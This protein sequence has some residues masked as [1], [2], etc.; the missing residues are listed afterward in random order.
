LTV[1]LTNFPGAWEILG[2]VM[3]GGTLHIRG[4]GDDRWAEC[5]R[6][7]DI[8]TAT[9]SVVLKHMPRRQDF[10]NI[11]TIAVGGE[12]CPV[13]LAE[14]WAPHVNFWN[15][16]GPTEISILNTAHLHKA[17]GILSIGKP[18]PNTNVYI[19]NDDESPARI[20]QPG[21]MWAGGLGV[22]RGYLN[23]PELTAARYKV[24]KFTRDG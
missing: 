10:P 11:Q 22:S 20:G 16:C 14:H 1:W 23:L 2:T 24:D 18:N 3:N 19:L 7:V 17:G 8:V 21:V 6:R 12:P 9:P 13:A 5:L 15:V 4:S